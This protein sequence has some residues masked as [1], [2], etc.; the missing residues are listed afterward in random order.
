MKYLKFS[1][2][3]FL[4]PVFLLS[5]DRDYKTQAQKQIEIEREVSKKQILIHLNM[6]EE[7][8]SEGN[9]PVALEKYENFLILYENSEFTFDASYKVAS[10]Y[11]KMN[12]LPRAIEAFKKAYRIAYNQEKGLQAYLNAGRLYRETG[13]YKTAREIFYEISQK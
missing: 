4:F 3:F 10:I 2:F 11:Q 9:L 7:I 12:D 8:E 1:V 5:L 13:D 6:A